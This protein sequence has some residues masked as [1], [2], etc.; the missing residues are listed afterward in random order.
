[1]A[2]EKALPQPSSSINSHQLMMAVPGALLL[3]KA[4]EGDAPG[5]ILHG[6][7]SAKDFSRE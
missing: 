7:S 5:C 6:L 4:D 3:E 1:M 2:G